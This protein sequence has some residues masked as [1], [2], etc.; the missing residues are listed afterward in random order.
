MLDTI[1]TLYST[2]I[3]VYSILTS[4]L[5]I[6]WVYCKKFS[7]KS[8]YYHSYSLERPP[9]FRPIFWIIRGGVFLQSFYVAYFDFQNALG[10]SNHSPPFW[11]MFISGRKTLIN[12]PDSSFASFNFT[13]IPQSVSH[14]Q[15]WH[16]LRKIAAPRVKR[17]IIW[18]VSES[19]L[20]E[21][22][23]T[24]R[25]GNPIRLLRWDCLSLL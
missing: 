7:V 11:F 2:Q 24:L 6:F 17:F 21:E 13:N 8:W 4:Y 20:S 16:K 19:I 1:F 18:P 23:I 15:C 12:I 5:R 14:L 10:E 9:P 22:A 25:V 3:P